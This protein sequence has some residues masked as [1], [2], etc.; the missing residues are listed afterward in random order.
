MAERACAEFNIGPDRGIAAL[1]ASEIPA[2]SGVFVANACCRLAGALCGSSAGAEGGAPSPAR[3]PCSCA[4]GLWNGQA[5]PA[6]QEGQK[7]P[8]AGIA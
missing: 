4:P 2:P 8:A 1:N 7:R 6:M 3:P 5:E